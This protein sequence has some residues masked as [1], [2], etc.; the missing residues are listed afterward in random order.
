MNIGMKA[1]Y[2]NDAIVDNIRK[3]VVSDIQFKLDS[4]S[5]KTY[6]EQYVNHLFTD[7]SN[8]LIDF[9]FIDMNRKTSSNVE[10]YNYES[11]TVIL[12]T[13]VRPMRTIILQLDS[14][15]MNNAYIITNVDDNTYKY[16]L[17]EKEKSVYVSY[18]KK[19][20]QIEFDGG[21][22]Y[23]RLNKENST[24]SYALII[25][26]F[27]ENP[28]YVNKLKIHSSFIESTN[29]VITK[30]E[31][32]VLIEP[33]IIEETDLLTYSFFEN[34]LYKKQFPSSQLIQT[35]S[36]LSDNNYIQIVKHT[37]KKVELPTC[38]NDISILIDLSNNIGNRFLQRFTKNM[39]SPNTCNW[40]IDEYTKYN[41]KSDV[42]SIEKVPIVFNYVFFSFKEI[43]EY[44]IKSYCVDS[45][46][47]I[48]I[49]SGDFIKYKC[50]DTNDSIGKGV[51]CMI[52]LSK[53]ADIIF[54]DGLTYKL[55]QGDIL[56]YKKQ[57]F[58]VNC[59][60]EV[61]IILFDI[62]VCL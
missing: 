33:S 2:V 51:S 47:K 53:N 4:S 61:Y 6:T 36:H 32:I 11:Q 59:D 45:D 39:Y 23:G 31:N 3:E 52:I 20:F 27:N 15:S 14:N 16:K 19:G 10:I 54:N 58:T 34:L 37:V 7:N 1:F 55:N 44:F 5:V 13:Y 62:T 50:N 29:E 35:M 17:F 30:D 57:F 46:I 24:P 41:E 60:D 26:I 43:I 48:S 25:N 9:H 21:H 28:N 42:L 8:N 38:H 22:F 18:P 40:M 12:K 49:T 56:L